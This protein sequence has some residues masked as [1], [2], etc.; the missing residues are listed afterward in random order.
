[1]SQSLPERILSVY[2]RLATRPGG[3]ITL[4]DLRAH[5]GAVS[6]GDL[7]RTLIAMDRR[8]EIQLEPDPDRA[9]LTSEAWS[10]VSLGGQD[11]HL[12]RAVMR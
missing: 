11:M 2:E 3:T 1:V 12:M 9:A 7:N 5:L 10:A 6:L 8:R 4:V